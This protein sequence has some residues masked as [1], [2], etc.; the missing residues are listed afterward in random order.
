MGRYHRRRGYGSY[1]RRRDP[2]A[3]F[4]F[5]AV[6]FVIAACAAAVIQTKRLSTT[7]A[8]IEKLEKQVSDLQTRLDEV[9]KVVPQA[10]LEQAVSGLALDYQK[11]YP[12]MKAEAG[13]FVENDAK[14]VYLTFDDGP[15]I[16]YRSHSGCAQA[17][18]SKGNL[19]CSRKEY[20]GTRSSYQADC[21]RR[22]YHRHSRLFARLR[23]DL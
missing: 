6:L 9:N 19:F 20:C 21:R 7:D 14:A 2:K 4:K 3:F 13:T 18:R 8:Q 1:R 16:Q 15:F 11:L 17:N 12:E 10:L 22:A 5:A 23:R